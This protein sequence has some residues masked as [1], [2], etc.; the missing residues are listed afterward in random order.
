MPKTLNECKE[1]MVQ[2]SEN[3]DFKASEV[4]NMLTD[5]HKHL[6]RGYSNSLTFTIKDIVDNYESKTPVTKTDFKTFS[7]DVFTVLNSEKEVN[8]T[9]YN[10]LPWLHY[11]KTGEASIE[12]GDS[13]KG[14][15]VE[16]PSKVLKTY[17]GVDE[18]SMLLKHVGIK[19]TVLVYGV[20][21]LIKRR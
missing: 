10:Y 11:L 16:F 6:T 21:L 12:N 14:T 1:M 19:N 9:K 17:N 20:M 18:L 15:K 2:I 7:E 8:L 4:I 13:L 5:L 3:E